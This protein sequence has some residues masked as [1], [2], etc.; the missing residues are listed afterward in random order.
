MSLV[1][2]FKVMED[3]INIPRLHKI[4][5]YVTKFD[6]KGVISEQLPNPAIIRDGEDYFIPIL[7][8]PETSRVQVAV[9]ELQY[10]LLNDLNEHKMTIIKYIK[11]NQ[12]LMSWATFN[13]GV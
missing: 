6:N 11:L 1:V 10:S 4:E 12:T 3:T 7:F 13:L 2:G 8:T 5:V 9:N